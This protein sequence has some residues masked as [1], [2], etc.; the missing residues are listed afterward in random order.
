MSRI[1]VPE[2]LRGSTGLGRQASAVVAE[3]QTYSVASR[4]QGNGTCAAPVAE[5]VL[6]VG[7]EIVRDPPYRDGLLG[8]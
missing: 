4:F 6:A 7:D 3:A 5:G 2:P 8:R 1:P